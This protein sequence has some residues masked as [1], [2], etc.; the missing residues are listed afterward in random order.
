MYFKALL[1]Y[2]VYH[3]LTIKANLNNNEKGVLLRFYIKNYLLTEYLH[4]FNIVHSF[5]II[6]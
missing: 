1:L 5:L 3:L 2:I 6:L 4:T